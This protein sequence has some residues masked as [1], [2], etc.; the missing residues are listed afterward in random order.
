MSAESLD[1]AERDLAEAGPGGFCEDCG[2]FA[3]RHIGSVP[4]DFPKANNEVCRCEGMLWKGERVDILRVIS[5]RLDRL[6][7]LN[8]ANEADRSDASVRSEG[9]GS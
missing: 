6:V 7:E 9:E 2:H 4:C 3:V 8:A 5:I 1:R